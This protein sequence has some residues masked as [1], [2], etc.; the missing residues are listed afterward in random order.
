M[1]IRQLRVSF[2]AMLAVVVLTACSALG[3][4][5]PA[6]SGA[7]S[8]PPS[9]TSAPTQPS[10]APTPSANLS[11]TPVT[12]TPSP[13]AVSQVSSPAQAAALVFASNP[14]FAAITPPAKGVAGQA[15][16]YQAFQSGAGFAVAVTMGSGD[17]LSGCINNHTWNYTVSAKGAV[18]LVSE[19]GDPVEVSIDH[20]T[21]D[22][23]TVTVKLVAGPVC[24]VE[25]DPPDPS[26]APR[27]VP[28]VEVVLRDPSGAEVARGTSDPTGQIS[29]TV[30]AGA[31]YLEPAA[32]SGLMRQ[33]E[34]E[35]FSV[36]GGS[37]VILTLEYDTGIR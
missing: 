12:P 31:Y 8:S 3:P 22:P 11:T 20:G 30:P 26:C 36:V 13:I 33:A 19:Q 32:A 2:P 28:D 6:P 37:S 27:P 21:S 24:P 9:P 35:A 10:P 17:C 14:L 29:F 5:S 7:P 18:Q 4:G 15:S 34:P 25:R 16:S 1:N 23:A